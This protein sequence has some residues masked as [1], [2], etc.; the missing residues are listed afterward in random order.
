MKLRVVIV[1]LLLVAVAF[2]QVKPTGKGPGLRVKNTKERLE[3]TIRDFLAGVNTPAAHDRFWSDDLIYTG[4][5][6]VVRTKA[7]IMKNVAEAAK[8]P[9]DSKESKSTYDAEDIVVHDYGDFAVVNFRLIH[10]TEQDGKP[11]TANY[12]NTGTFRKIK[13][14]WKVIA[15]QATK[16]EERK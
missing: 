5:T 15:W 3:S 14:E 16:I 2:G 4:S 9:A 11:I 13:G 8:K 6:G 7:E 12:R 10:H 1:L